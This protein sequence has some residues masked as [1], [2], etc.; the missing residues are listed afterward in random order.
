MSRYLLALVGIAA[1]VVVAGQL[2]RKTQPAVPFEEALLKA[3]QQLHTHG[4]KICEHDAGKMLTIRNDTDEFRVHTNKNLADKYA[5]RIVMGAN[6]VLD[7]F[8]H[9][10]KSCQEY[11]SAQ[12]WNWSEAR[13]EEI[14]IG[15][16]IR[17]A[18]DTLR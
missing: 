8:M 17:K 18:K 6:H 7:V 11:A 13:L 10:I 2:S 3:T 15:K 16:T 4:G 14:H 9:E 1:I 12:D 5:G